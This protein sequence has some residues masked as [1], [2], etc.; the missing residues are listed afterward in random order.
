M[1]EPM[2]VK[3]MRAHK[4]AILAQ[5][6]SKMEEMARRWLQVEKKL[7]D[8]L[9]ALA[10]EAARM[11]GDGQVINK[12]VAMRIERAQKLLY[13]VRAETGRYVEWADGFISDYQALLAEQGLEHATDAIMAVMKEYD[14]RG[15]FDKLNVSAVE[16]MIGLAGDGSPLKRYLGD[17]HSGAADGM[18]EALING[19]AQGIHPTKIAEEMAN[20][21]GIGLQQAM[22][23]ARTESLRAYRNASLMQYDASGLVIGYKRISA[24]DERTCAGCLFTD[25]Q[26]FEDLSQFDEH[27]QGRCAAVPVLEGLPET[28]WQDPFDWFKAQDET[29]QESILGTGRFDAWKNGASL[30]SMVKRVMDPTWGGAYVPTPVQELGN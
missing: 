25:G 16:S 27:N 10:L 1:P 11:K 7:K 15:T 8:D 2:V 5:E 24:R 30:E 3:I 4:N 22:N 26:V 17:V 29:T 9:Q 13:Q 21:L 6:D 19:V 18:L 28:Q 14:V 20:G 23:T 12:A